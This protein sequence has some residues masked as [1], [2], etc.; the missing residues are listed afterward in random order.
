MTRTL[1]LMGVLPPTRSKVPRLQHAQNLRLRGGRHVAD[2]IE[3]NRAACCIARTCRCVAVVA[4][5]NEPRSWPNSSLSSSCSGIAAQ[6]MARNGCALRWLWLIDRAGDEFLARAALAGD[7]RGGVARGEL[8]D[9]F[10]H[11]AASARCG[12]RCRVRNLQIPAAVDTR[13]LASCR[14]RL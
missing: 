4:P 13:R 14:A 1:T 11:I 12:R 6:L 10:E 9:E 5:V 2:F 8:A 3:K 7:E